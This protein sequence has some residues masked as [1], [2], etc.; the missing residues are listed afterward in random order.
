MPVKEMNSPSAIPRRARLAAAGVA[1]QHRREGALRR[2]LLQYS[3]HI[4]VRVAR[5]DDERQAGGARG[6]DVVAKSAFLG[7]SRAVVVVVVEPGLADRNHLGMARAA[8]Q[9]VDA[10]IEL[11]LGVVR[12]GADRAVHV[13][14]ALGD[15]EHLG[16]SLD[17]GRDADDARNAGAAC[18]RDDAVELA[19]KVRENRGGSG[20]RSAWC[21]KREFLGLSGREMPCQHRGPVAQPRRHPPAHLAG[22]VA[23]RSPPIKGVAGR[24]GW[25]TDEPSDPVV[26]R[27]CSM[28]CLA[29]GSAAASAA[30]VTAVARRDATHARHEI[31]CCR[32]LQST[33]ARSRSQ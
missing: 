31:R 8:D 24:C 30:V 6:G 28:R 11:L 26:L 27:N 22:E 5:M 23:S 12:M 10:D 17:V 3:R 13:G 20:C 19:G 32:D 18:A 29:Q 7:L 9:L 1:M 14:E 2:L 25:A 33:A 21:V 15:G 16:V 4:L